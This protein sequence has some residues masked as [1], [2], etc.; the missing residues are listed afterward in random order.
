MSFFAKYPAALSAFRYSSLEHPLFHCFQ[1]FCFILTALSRT[2]FNYKVSLCF[3]QPHTIE[4]AVNDVEKEE[5][6]SICTKKSF[7]GQNPEP[8][9]D[10]LY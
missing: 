8:P 2:L 6:H 5:A 9:K 3:W 7:I 1:A 4:D 10:N